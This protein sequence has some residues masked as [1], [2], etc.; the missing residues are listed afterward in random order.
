MPRNIEYRSHPNLAVVNI[1]KRE[2]LEVLVNLTSKSLG[3]TK[4]K[5]KG[6]ENSLLVNFAFVW[7]I[8]VTGTFTF[9]N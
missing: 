3:L 2:T 9:K 1:I 4:R 6:G 5:K 8:R 7:T